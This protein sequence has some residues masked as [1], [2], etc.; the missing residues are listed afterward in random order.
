MSSLAIPFKAIHGAE[1]ALAS[2]SL[3]FQSYQILMKIY[4]TA[5][6]SCDLPFFHAEETGFGLSNSSFASAPLRR[7]T[8]ICELDPGVH[9]SPFSFVLRAYQ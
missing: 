2:C 3:E 8:Q 7:Q 9:L 1:Q 4:G 5:E 6:S